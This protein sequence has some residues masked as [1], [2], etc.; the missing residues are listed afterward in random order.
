MN[1]VRFPISG[2]GG[3]QFSLF[4]NGLHV[5]LGPRAEFQIGGV[6]HNFVQ[7]REKGSGS[8]ND[9]GDFS[10]STKLKLVEERGV[11]PVVSFR[12]TVVL[13]NTN[14]DKG[15]GTDGTHFSFSEISAL[16]FWTMRFGPPP[17]RMS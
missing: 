7:V 14:N 1:R 2:I 8:R 4:A 12:P 10:I 15:L 5:G 17:S 9:W 13:P 16:A 11:L 3:N 6:L